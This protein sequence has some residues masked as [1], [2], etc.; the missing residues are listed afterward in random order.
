MVSF[1][2]QRWTTH[3]ILY[4]YPSKFQ[5]V[6][7]MWSWLIS[8]RKAHCHYWGCENI[9][10]FWNWISVGWS[11]LHS[12]GSLLLLSLCYSTCICIR[13]WAFHS[14]GCDLCAQAILIHC[15]AYHGIRS[16]VGFPWFCMS[17]AS[18]D[19]SSFDLISHH[20]TGLAYHGSSL[21]KVALWLVFTSW[22]MAYLYLVPCLFSSILQC[23]RYCVWANCIMKVAAEF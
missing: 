21:C 18:L 13:S 6:L 3:D 4:H 19:R 10:S 9:C 1:S 14:P 5:T 15:N 22:F 2:F 11:V 8:E 12:F 23:V 17:T 7:S 20:M 16:V